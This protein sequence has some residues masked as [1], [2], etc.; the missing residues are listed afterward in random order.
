VIGLNGVKA[1]GGF[2]DES[3]VGVIV[4]RPQLTEDMAQLAAL[5]TDKN[6]RRMGIASRLTQQLIQQAKEE[7]HS[8]LYVSATPSESAVNFYIS[9][10]FVPTQQVHPKLYELEPDDIHMIKALS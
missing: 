8:K 9:Q 2:D 1:W 3:L 4:Y 10:G 7:G 6:H 5:F